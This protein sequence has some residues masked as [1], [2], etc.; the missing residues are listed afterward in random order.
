M[1]CKTPGEYV[2]NYRLWRILPH[3]RDKLSGKQK[4]MI[5]R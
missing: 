3:M 4:Q 5:Y 1:I 2:N